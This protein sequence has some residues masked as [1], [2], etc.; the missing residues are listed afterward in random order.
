M[1][2]ELAC[3]HAPPCLGF[4]CRGEILADRPGRLQ[5]VGAAVDDRELG[6][7]REAELVSD[8]HERAQVAQFRRHATR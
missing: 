6:G 8:R 2:E 4:Q 3:R 7:A 5:H 1:A